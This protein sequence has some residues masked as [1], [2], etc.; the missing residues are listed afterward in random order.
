MDAP[1]VLSFANNR[2]T[3]ALVLFI[4]LGILLTC[5]WSLLRPWPP[6]IFAGGFFVL[7]AVGCLTV[8]GYVLI[9]R[10]VR[11]DFARGEVHLRQGVLG[12]QRNQQW[13]LTAFQRVEVTPRYTRTASGQKEVQP[14]ST[15]GHERTDY[16]SV[17]LVGG[18]RRILLEV[19]EQL[20]EAEAQAW[21]I[22]RLGDWQ[23]W[24]SGYSVQRLDSVNRAPSVPTDLTL[25][26]AYALVS[27][28]PG[29]AADTPTPST[30]G[31]TRI[32]HY[33]QQ[34][35]DGVPH[36]VAARVTQYPALEG[37]MDEQLL[38][39]TP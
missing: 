33:H 21:Q 12:L 24:R 6:G 9:D 2:Q 25:R 35:T 38:P 5:A 15:S 18:E 27:Q 23:A 11:L 17:A 34:A 22:A 29:N 36:R 3:A 20:P 28:V 10:E 19:H 7:I 32:L 8:I 4:S 1:E 30:Q 39:N 14:R 13:P 37:P 31:R 16:F 26:G